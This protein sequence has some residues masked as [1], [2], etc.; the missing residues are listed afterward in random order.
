MMR[1]GVADGVEELRCD[2]FFLRSAGG[3][4]G[5]E[6]DEAAVH[7]VVEDVGQIPSFE[8]GS[9]KCISHRTGMCGGYV[10]LGPGEIVPVVGLELLQC[11]LRHTVVCQFVDIVPS[12]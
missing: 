6:G 3:V 7:F 8:I 11:C 12:R 1:H 4:A 9:Y 2:G 10:V 5:R